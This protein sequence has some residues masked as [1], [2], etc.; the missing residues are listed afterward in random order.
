MEK[1]SANLSS[2]VLAAMTLVGGYSHAVEYPEPVS[3]TQSQCTDLA[4]KSNLAMLSD[5]IS[6]W[7]NLDDI[8]LRLLRR[9][10]D[11]GDF[12]D[13]TFSRISELLSMVR[14]LEL[15]LKSASPHPAFADQHLEFRRA[16]A[17]TRARLVQLDSVYKQAV[18]IPHYVDTKI[19]LEGLRA[20]ADF[21][22]E[23]LAKI[24]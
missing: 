21:T 5:L 20:L 18:R 1:K 23:R 4:I 10:M 12:N 8:Y 6:G 24:A 17:N 15:A 7:K 14:G 22:T 9:T 2:F 3:K 11:T 13:E 16:V 19:D